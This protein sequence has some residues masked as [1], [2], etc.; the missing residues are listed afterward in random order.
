MFKT[1]TRSHFCYWTK[2]SA[3]DWIRKMIVMVAALM[4]W[5]DPLVSLRHRFCRDKYL[6][7]TRIRVKREVLCSSVF[8]VSVDS[9]CLCGWHLHGNKYTLLQSINS[10]LSVGLQQDV[11]RTSAAGEG[12]SLELSRASRTA[13]PLGQPGRCCESFVVNEMKCRAER[14]RHRRQIQNCLS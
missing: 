1:C 7:N 9:V 12:W 2:Y 5:A 14:L 10:R 4:M 8:L 6:Q 13:G 3:D 11:H